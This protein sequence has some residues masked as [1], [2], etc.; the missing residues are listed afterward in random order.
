MIETSVL[1]DLT[2]DNS[3]FSLLAPGLQTAVDSTSLGAF[4][5]CPRYYFYSIIMGLQPLDGIAVHFD[6]GIFIHLGVE[7]YHQR[8]VSGA[9]HEDALDSALVA[10]LFATWNSKLRRPWISD[11]R[12]KNRETLVRS[13]VWYLDRFANRPDP[14]ETIKLANGRAAVELSFRFDSGWRVG[15]ETIQFCG[16]LDRLGLLN[17]EPVIPDVKTTGLH[18]DTKWFNQW[19]PGNQFSMYALAGRVAFEL[20]TTKIIVDGM[21]INAGWTK[22]ERG[23]VSRPEAIVDEWHEASGAWVENMAKSA[24]DRNW[25]MNDRAC[26]SAFG[27]MCEFMELCA[28]QPNTRESWAKGA[29]RRRQWDPLKIRGDV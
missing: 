27:R 29:Y 18:I 19:T 22:F 1:I 9:S 6:F 8:W 5:H 4:K 2:R 25:P 11:H 13:L 17:D 10:V 24:R 14:I 3:S 20:P 12:V 7:T 15:G 23:I 21:E 26:V 16:H 28:R